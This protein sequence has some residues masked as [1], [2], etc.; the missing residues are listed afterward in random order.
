MS[1]ESV[2]E[3]T[4]DKKTDTKETVVTTTTKETVVKATTNLVTSV[5]EEQK[6]QESVVNGETEGK[7][8]H[9]F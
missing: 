3:V 1:V 5:E 6:V 8:L 2:S 7:L 4:N 9:K